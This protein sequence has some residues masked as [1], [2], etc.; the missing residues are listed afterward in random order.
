MYNN[1]ELVLN[2]AVPCRPVEISRAVYPV[3]VVYHVTIVAIG[4]GLLKKFW[5]LVLGCVLRTAG[6]S[7]IWNY[8]DPL[9]SLEL[10]NYDDKKFEHIYIILKFKYLSWS[11]ML[12]SNRDEPD[13]RPF[14]N[15]ISVRISWPDARFW[16]KLYIRSLKPNKWQKSDK[17]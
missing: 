15:P 3:V 8:A 16:P 6:S 13:I 10:L 1:L 2:G 17:K 7:I 14:H 12:I 4:H 9:T 5:P 11:I